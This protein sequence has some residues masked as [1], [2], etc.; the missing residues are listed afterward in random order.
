MPTCSVVELARLIGHRRTQVWSTDRTH[1]TAAAI[2]CERQDHVVTRARGTHTRPNLLDDAGRFMPQDH[3]QRVPATVPGA[4][5]NVVV[6]VAG[7][8]GRD[9]QGPALFMIPVDGGAPVRLVEG[10]WVNPVWSPNGQLIVYGGVRHAFTNP[11][12]DKAVKH[13]SPTVIAAD[14]ASKEERIL[15]I[16]EE[17]QE[18]L[19]E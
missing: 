15:K 6:A 7:A 10:K 13:R 9:A 2:R 3:R 5:H 4:V 17:I 18:L 1:A 16:M 11:N 12:A 14:I 19:S 8:G